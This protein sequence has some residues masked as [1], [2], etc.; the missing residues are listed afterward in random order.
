MSSAPSGA[1]PPPVESGN[2]SV[3]TYLSQAILPQLTEA[4]SAM[5]KVK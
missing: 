5:E 3:R 1:P 4:L 2:E